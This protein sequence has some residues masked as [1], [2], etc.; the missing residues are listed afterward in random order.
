MGGISIRLRRENSS[1]GKHK[2]KE[3]EA[4]AKADAEGSGASTPDTQ[5]A[6]EASLMSNPLV[7]GL[8]SDF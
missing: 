5:P 8:H 1:L 2:R 6:R 4:V 3:E 7:R